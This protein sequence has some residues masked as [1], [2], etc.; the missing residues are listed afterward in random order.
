MNQFGTNIQV[1]SGK[2]SSYKEDNYSDVS[3]MSMEMDDCINLTDFMSPLK[4]NMEGVTYERVSQENDNE[5]ATYDDVPKYDEDDNVLV[6]SVKTRFNED[7][8][9]KKQLHILGMR[10]TNPKQ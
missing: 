7:V 8:P 5:A 4:N 6:V 3:N 9:W 1:L 10:F 2:I